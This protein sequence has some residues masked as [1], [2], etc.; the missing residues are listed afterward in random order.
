K[1]LEKYF[2]AFKSAK[3]Q[4]APASPAIYTPGVITKEKDI[5]QVHVC[6]GFPGVAMD[7]EA[8]YDMSVFN[9]MFGGG[10]SSRLFQS[11][12]EEHGLAYSI[13]S[14]NSGY[15]DAGLFSIYAA[16]AEDQVRDMIAL[17]FQETDK[18]FTDRISE[19]QLSKAKEQLKSNY[20]LSLE[21]TTSRM[22]A[23][24]R[25]M[26]MLGRV[27]PVDELIARIDAVSL[28]GLYALIGG[29]LK[30]EQASLSAVGDIGGLDFASICQLNGDER[31]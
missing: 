1:K 15:S 3:K 6:L 4:P 10:M 13:Y 11:I 16:C 14:Y 19:I 24:G 25:A 17:I 8:T 23:I 12:R 7:S 18:L 30:K 27:L 31:N 2:G 22:N 21:N 9:A 29:L 28:D 26:L 20:I 5:E